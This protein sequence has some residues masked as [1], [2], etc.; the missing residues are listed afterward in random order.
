[1]NRI[2]WKVVTA[3]GVIVVVAFLVGLGLFGG[4][5]AGWGMM[6]P[7]MMR[8]WGYGAFGWIGAIFMWLIPIS[9]LVLTVLGI[10]W[11][12]N[13]VTGGGDRPSLQTQSCPSC[14]KG[15]QTDWQNCPY[16]GTALSHQ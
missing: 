14:G 6:G 13:A 8:G 4:R 2:N 11:L 16:C 12:V 1:M 9:F 5:T 7:G 3:F 15:V 10:T